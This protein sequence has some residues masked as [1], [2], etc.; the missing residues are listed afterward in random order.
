MQELTEYIHICTAIIDKISQVQDRLHDL[1][2]KYVWIQE[3]SL[4]MQNISERV[5]E[6]QKQLQETHGQLKTY[7][8]YFNDYEPILRLFNNATSCV[9]DSFV[10]ML[11]RMDECLAF[12]ESKVVFF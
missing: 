12:M 5:L 8:G 11:K 10:P 2:Q 4:D 9:E 3:K 7:L 1:H 6:E